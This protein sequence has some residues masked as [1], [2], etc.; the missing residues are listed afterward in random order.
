MIRFWRFSKNLSLFIRSPHRQGSI[1]L[2]FEI[3][4][5]IMGNL[6]NIKAS[7]YFLPIQLNKLAS[8]LAFLQRNGLTFILVIGQNG[9]NTDRSKLVEQTM[10]LTDVLESQGAKTRPLINCSGVLKTEMY[11]YVHYIDQHNSL[12]FIKIYNEVE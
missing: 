7:I 10:Q 2:D 4:L 9:E 11:V 8:S 12:T 5:S 1:I 3:F 6:V